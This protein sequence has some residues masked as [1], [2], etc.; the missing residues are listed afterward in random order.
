MLNDLYTPAGAALS[1]TPW[2][3]YPRPQLKRDNYVNLN[4]LWV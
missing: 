3:C 1:G 4:G 2:D